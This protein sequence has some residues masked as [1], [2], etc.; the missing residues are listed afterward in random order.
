MPV[1]LSID[2][3][4]ASDFEFEGELGSIGSDA[5]PPDQFET[6]EYRFPAKV[7]LFTQQ[8]KLKMA[9]LFLL[10]RHELTSM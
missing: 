3:F 10:R 6:A 9:N 1:D 5:L 8:L 2:S 7:R 4:P